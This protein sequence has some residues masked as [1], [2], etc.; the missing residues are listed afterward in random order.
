MG[1]MSFFEKNKKLG[2][3]DTFILKFVNYLTN[4]QKQNEKTSYFQKF[5]CKQ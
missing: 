4:H 3:L 2:T 1:K 5:S